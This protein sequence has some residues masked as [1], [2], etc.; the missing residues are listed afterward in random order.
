MD[1]ARENG[2]TVEECNISP[3]EIYTADEVFIS[4]TTR[5]AMPVTLCDG[6]KA[7]NG[8]PG[9]ISVKLQSIYQEKLDNMLENK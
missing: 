1:A 7:G 6:K 5:G 3:E 2:I 4:N 9:P 8:K